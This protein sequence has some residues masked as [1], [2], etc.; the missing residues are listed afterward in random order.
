MKTQELLRLTVSLVVERLI[1]LG[2]S[3]IGA[4]DYL[5][6]HFLFLALLFNEVCCVLACW[7]MA[8]KS[9]D[10]LYCSSDDPLGFW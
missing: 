8:S 7:E 9:R 10:V 5:N 2:H 1:L 6:H 3:G 4:V